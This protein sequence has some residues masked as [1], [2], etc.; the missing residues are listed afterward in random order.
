MIKFFRKIR[1]NL[2]ETGKT[3]KYFKYAIIGGL[4]YKF[5]I[6]SNFKQTKE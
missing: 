4:S 3:G 5:K 1:Y 2:I 6:I